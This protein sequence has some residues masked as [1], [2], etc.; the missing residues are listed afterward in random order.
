MCTC[1]RGELGTDNVE[2]KLFV[3]I[4]QSDREPLRFFF[5]EV[6]AFVKELLNY[7]QK[8]LHKK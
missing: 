5:L 8:K 7:K 2:R 1:N 4:S 6:N 3:S